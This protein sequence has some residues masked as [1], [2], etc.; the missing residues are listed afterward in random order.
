MRFL[1]KSLLLILVSTVCTA[2]AP[3]YLQLE[4][5][6]STELIK[7]YPGQKIKFTTKAYPE[8]WRKEK[9]INIIPEENL[10]ILSTGYISPEDI[11]SVERAN[12]GPVILGHFLSKFAAGWLVFGA[13]ASLADSG[14]KMSWT[15][16]IIGTVAAG[17]GW[18][19]RKLFGK[20][21][22]PMEKF[23]RLRIMDIRFPTPYIQTP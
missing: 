21:K 3:I 18:L 23:Y 16:V 1:I 2:Q 8:A 14:Y 17:V 9:I 22:Y 19:M 4:E 13:Y 6:N 10:I 5:I 11:H 15:E 20:K 12:G 7:Y